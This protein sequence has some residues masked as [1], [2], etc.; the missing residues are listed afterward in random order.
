[1]GDACAVQRGGVTRETVNSDPQPS[2]SIAHVT[3]EPSRVHSPQPYTNTSHLD[4]RKRRVTGNVA[5]NEI[6]RLVTSCDGQPAE[7]VAKTIV[8][9]ARDAMCERQSPAGRPPVGTRG[10]HSRN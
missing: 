10:S 5:L 7:T 4:P 2:Q 1:M 9:A 6:A 8:A 3:V